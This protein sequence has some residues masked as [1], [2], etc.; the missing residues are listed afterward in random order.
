MAKRTPARRPAPAPAKRPAP[1]P[2]PAKRRPAPKRR[3]AAPQRGTNISATA[4]SAEGRNIA[5][6]NVGFINQNLPTTANTFTGLQ[7]GQIDAQA[8]RLD[9]QYTQDARAQVNQSFTGADQLGNMGMR[10]ADMGD[11]AGQQISSLAPLAQQQAGFAADNIYGL[12]PQVTQIGD[13]AAAN[14]NALAPQVVGIGDATAANINALAPQVTQIGDEYMGQIGGL[15]GMLADQAR[16]GFATS[17]P[18]SIEQSLYDQGQADLALGRSLSAGELRDATQSARQGMA[19][20]GMATG[21]GALSAEILNRDRFANQRLNQRRAFAAEANNLR[22]RN[23]MDR[24]TAAGDM[25][26]ASGNLFDTAGRL[27]MTGREMTGRMFDAAGRVGI[28]G[29]EAAGQLYDTGGRLGMTGREIS[30]R[31]FDAGGR[32]NVLGT[33]TAGDLMA[34]GNQAAMQGRQVG[35]NLLEGAGRLRQ[36][37]ATTLANLDPYSRAMQA[38]INIGQ[39]SGTAAGNMLGGQV[40]NMIDLSGNAA[41][42]N[43]NRMD[44]IFNQN[45]NNRAAGAAANAA[46]PQWWETG[47]GAVRSLFG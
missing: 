12:A 38:G 16:Q 4:I 18:T 34:T 3:P 28:A 9:N 1:A 15:G 39:F 14:V 42:F 40:N 44:S 5:A 45:Q 35:G 37:G 47:I 27:G 24:R 29:R 23:V 30:G 46:K 25:A 7:Q 17:G 8:A 36:S 2:A 26:T 33:Q 20:R 21:M 22:E 13:A 32:M 6:D 31:L 43:T 10:T 19:A 11:A 41:S